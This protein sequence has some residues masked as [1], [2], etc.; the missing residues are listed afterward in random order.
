M[1][2]AINQLDTRQTTQIRVSIPVGFRI[3]PLTLTTY[4]AILGDWPHMDTRH[5]Q[6]CPKLIPVKQIV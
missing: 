6:T 5:F 3:S 2:Q 1:D 4:P